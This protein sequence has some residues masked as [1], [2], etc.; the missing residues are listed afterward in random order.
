MARFLLSVQARGVDRA[1]ILGDER[2]LDLRLS[3]WG[4]GLRIKAEHM[5]SGACRM[6]LYLDQGGPDTGEADYLGWLEKSPRD[7][8]RACILEPGKGN[9]WNTFK[10]PRKGIEGE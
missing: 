2:G 4:L 5:A 9:V 7:T 10:L 1:P 6:H 3:T 8:L